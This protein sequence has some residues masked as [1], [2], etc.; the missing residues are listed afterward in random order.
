MESTYMY[1]REVPVFGFFD[2][3]RHVVPENRGNRTP[4]RPG[5]IILMLLVIPQQRSVAC[6]CIATKFGKPITKQG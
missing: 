1:R 2:F 5:T 6:A 3:P 4:A